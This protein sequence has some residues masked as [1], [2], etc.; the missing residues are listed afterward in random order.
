LAVSGGGE[1]NLIHTNAD[2]SFVGG[3]SGNTVN[4]GFAVIGGGLNNQVG[5]SGQY[6]TVSGGN[7]N[8]ANGDSAAIGGGYSNTASGNYAT[9]PGG[10][11][12]EASGDYSFAAGR[13]A[14][15]TG[16]GCFVWADSTNA[17][18]TCSTANRTIFRSSGGFYIYTS[19]DLSAGAYLAAGSGSWSS[20][21]DRD[22]KENFEPVDP[23]AVLEKVAQLPITTWNYKA[24]DD[25]I[26]HIGPMAQDFY[27]AFGVGEDDT[28]ISTVDA[29]GVALAAIQGLY[30]RNQA[31]EEEVKTLRAENEA[32]RGQLVDLEARVEALEQGRTSR[33]SSAQSGLLPGAG[34]LLLGLVW[35]VRRRG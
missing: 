2:Y 26:R 16:Q 13:Q 27:A 25:S 1:Q 32:L 3:G 9:V 10:S 6:A 22:A 4:Q 29:D 34:L 33:T 7:S 19:G 35:A 24:Q 15:A 17:S 28:H 18:V 21:S 14:Y 5:T 12:N 31:L 11:F 8:V 30:R 23:Q 20:V